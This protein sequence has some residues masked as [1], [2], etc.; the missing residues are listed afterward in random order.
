LVVTVPGRLVDVLNFDTELDQ[1]RA[2]GRPTVVVA[3][4]ALRVR[5][6][7]SVVRAPVESAR[8]VRT[9]DVGKPS[10]EWGWEDLRNY[11]TR[12]IQI[13]F[14][15]FPIDPVKHRAIFSSFCTRHGEMAGPIAVA[16]FDLF[17]GR[18]NGAPISVNRFCKAS[19]QYFA[20][21][22]KERLINS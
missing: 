3:A 4:P 22:I 2:Q 19:D 7:V 9:T 17:G 15:D 11:V 16:A 5:E 20:I 8:E 13:S 1:A 6:T 10:A 12:Q 14:G 18:W 21:P